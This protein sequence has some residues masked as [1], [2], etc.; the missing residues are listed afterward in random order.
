MRQIL[1]TI[2]FLSAIYSCSNKRESFAKLEEGDSWVEKYQDGVLNYLVVYD[3]FLLGSTH[4]TPKQDYLYCLNLINGKVEWKAEVKER[5][6][7]QVAVDDNIVYYSSFIGQIETFDFEGKKLWNLRFP[8]NFSSHEVNNINGNL[9]VE[10]VSNGVYEYSKENGEL[11]NHWG[12][13]NLGMTLPVFFDNHMYFG[14]FGSIKGNRNSTFVKFDYGK[15]SVIYSQPANY[16][17]EKLFSID[18]MIIGIDINKSNIVGFSS[19]SGNILWEYETV[20]RGFSIDTRISQNMVANK[21][22]N[23]NILLLDPSTGVKSSRIWEPQ[24]QNFIIGNH[25]VIIE[26][27]IDYH[28]P[29]KV[30]VL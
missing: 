16:N 22:R 24:I 12:K 7:Q 19:N 28:E 3:N 17:F 20:E 1:M 10:S 13:G 4:L 27:Q 8:S 2:I 18:S 25:M 30:E 14:N 26:E 6:S 5:A 15:D 11:V 9:L 23:G 21:E 29:I